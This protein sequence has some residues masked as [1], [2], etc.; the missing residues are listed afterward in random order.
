MRIK[1]SIG[2]FLFL[3]TS[4][5]IL[6]SFQ[7]CGVPFDS[8]N[9]VKSSDS[10]TTSG[11]SG[12]KFQIINNGLE[13]SQVNV[14]DNYLAKIKFDHSYQDPRICVAVGEDKSCLDGEENYKTLDELNG[15][16]LIQ[17]G[18]TI[19]CTLRELSENIRSIF[20]E[21][22]SSLTLSVFFISELQD[23]PIKIGRFKVVNNHKEVAQ[24]PVASPVTTPA[25]SPVTSCGSNSASRTVIKNWN[26][27]SAPGNPIVTD[28]ITS[29]S[30]YAYKFTIDSTLYPRG[31]II[32]FEVPA[33]VDG[34]NRIDFSISTC[35]GDFSS[36]K[37]GC[38]FSNVKITNAFLIYPPSIQVGQC[39]VEPGKDYYLNI[40]PASGYS[41]VS[42]L[43]GS[44]G[45]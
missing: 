9:F 31:S 5:S 33:T 15:E 29:G 22:Q 30:V 19:E 45:M 23:S 36:P 13:A 40:R 18:E 27:Y 44:Q 39:T 20:P 12:L 26:N 43:L 1:K 17:N 10:S 35:P 42:K 16:Y 3:L 38:T 32:G 25:A 2:V 21:A 24:P 37:A 6:L 11:T 4:L 14:E 8:S 7:N 28:V 41:K 34:S